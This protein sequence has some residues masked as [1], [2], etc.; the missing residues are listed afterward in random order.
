MVRYQGR[1]PLPFNQFALPFRPLKEVVWS[2][3]GATGQT[4]DKEQTF[5]LELAASHPNIS[6][7]MMDDF[8]AA[9]SEEPGD[10]NMLAASPLDK[11]SELRSRLTVDRRRLNLWAALYDYQLD[12]PID[13]YLQLLDKVSLWTWDSQNLNG[14]KNNL[15]R[16]EKLAPTSG[17]TLGCYM[18]DYGKKRPMPLDLMQHQFELGLEWLKTGRIEG[19]IFLASCICDLE[20]EAVEWTRSWIATVGDQEI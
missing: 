12:K 1:P 4:D 11:L 2:V 18:W 8:F 17:K 9:G 5:V 20:L 15:E 19:I 10:R 3:V 16:L 14:L 13:K 7:V 6:G